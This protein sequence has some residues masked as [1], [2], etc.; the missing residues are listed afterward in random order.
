MANEFRASGTPLSQVHCIV[1]SNPVE[2]DDVLEVPTHQH[3]GSMYGRSRNV[4]SIQ[5]A[6]FTNDSSVK[7]LIGKPGG[8]FGKCDILAVRSRN[9]FQDQTDLT[10][11]SFQ[12]EQREV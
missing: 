6:C 10:G 7:V 11:R 4:L 12:F 2:V 5:S 3:V 8:L 9:V 1:P